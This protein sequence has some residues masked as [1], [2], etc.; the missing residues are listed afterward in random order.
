M[1]CTVAGLSGAECDDE[2]VAPAS[3]PF[4]EQPFTEQHSVST[5]VMT[6]IKSMSPTLRTP[7]PSLC[8]E[9]AEVVERLMTSLVSLPAPLPT[10]GSQ[11]V[12]MI[13]AMTEC[14]L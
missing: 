5:P 2:P 3:E 10:S 6:P 4:I 13:D 7:S 12:R 11:A 8:N 14:A 1:Y 9:P